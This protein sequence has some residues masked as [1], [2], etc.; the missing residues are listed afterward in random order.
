MSG[1]T[2]HQSIHIWR[3]LVERGLVLTCL[4]PDFPPQ[5][6]VSLMVFCLGDAWYGIPQ[7]RVRSIHA[8]GT[9]VPLPFAHPCIVGLTNVQNKPM[10]VLDLYPLLTNRQTARHPKGD[11]L[12][13]KLTGMDLGLLTDC[14]LLAPHPDMSP[15]YHEA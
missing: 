11:L 7:N 14:I 8:L 10:P 2:M 4:R 3:S 1:N 13:V 15:L 12:I 9:Y 6:T 5:Y